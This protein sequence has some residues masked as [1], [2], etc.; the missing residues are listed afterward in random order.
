MSGMVGEIENITVDVIYVGVV[1]VVRTL[2][3]SCLEAIRLQPLPLRQQLPETDLLLALV[4]N[5]LW[6]HPGH[7]AAVVPAFLAPATSLDRDDT[8]FG[9]L[10]N[11]IRISRLRMRPAPECSATVTNNSTVV[12]KMLL[13]GLGLFLANKANC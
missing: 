5:G 8:I 4:Q 9:P 1:P 10:A 12:A 11:E 2:H 7:Q 3:A 6:T 13:T